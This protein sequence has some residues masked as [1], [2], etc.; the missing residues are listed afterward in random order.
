MLTPR[1]KLRV[2]ALLKLYI[3]LV[4]VIH[5]ASYPRTEESVVTHDFTTVI[6][7]YTVDT[8]TLFKGESNIFYPQ[9]ISFSTAESDGLCGVSPTI[10]EEYVFGLF[11]DN[12]FDYADELGLSA[13]LCGLNMEWSMV[14]EGV[15]NECG[16]DPCD[17]EC[18]EFEVGTFIRAKSIWKE[19]LSLGQEARAGRREIS[20][21]IT[22]SKTSSENKHIFPIDEL[23]LQVT[24]SF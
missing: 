3:S 12:Q 10:G 20:Q 21:F 6:A 8:I 19:P 13:Y 23:V 7:K 11:A 17:G 9:E 1:D 15:L 2:R 22:F 18:D 4:V 16:D 5:R 14:D 24:A